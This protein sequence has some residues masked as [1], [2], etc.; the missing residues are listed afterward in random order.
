MDTSKVETMKESE[1]LAGLPH[2]NGREKL[3]EKRLDA[4]NDVVEVSDLPR[5]VCQYSKCADR[6][7]GKKFQPKRRA[8]MFCSPQ[9]RKAAWF[10][11]NFLRIEKP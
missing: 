9:C 3:P 11:N 4:S 7:R 8:Q 2:V 6:R 1:K 10:E 5:R